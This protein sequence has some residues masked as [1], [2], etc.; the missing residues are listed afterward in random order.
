MNLKTEFKKLFYSNLTE[1]ELKKEMGLTTTE[2]R[3]LYAWVKESDNLP[4]SYRRKPSRYSSYNQYSFYICRHD[5]I[6]D[7][8]IIIAYR[9]D[10]ESALNELSNIISMDTEEYIVEQATDENLKKLIKHEYYD[11]H[12]NW[13]SIM[14]CLQLP[15]HKFYYL[16]NEIKNEVNDNTNSNR[17]NRF[18]YR[19][20]PSKRFIIKKIIN[21]HPSY[22]GS[23]K[24]FDDAIKVR[25]FL[26]S[27]N[28]NDDAYR[29]YISK[30][31]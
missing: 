19:H 9:L 30:I 3:E 10:E 8:Y 22:F 15:Y 2:Y 6:T 26:E 20:N 12:K 25:D 29:K 23:Y 17:V 5:L 16:L 11:N 1:S 18:I 27:V 31:K 7:E 24:N 14:D 13:E 4:K 21:G 28:W